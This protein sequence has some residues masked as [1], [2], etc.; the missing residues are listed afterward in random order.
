MNAPAANNQFDL[1]AYEVQPGDNLHR[2]ISR[3]YGS[4]SQNKVQSIIQQILQANDP[5]RNPNLIRPGQII[6]LSVPRQHCAA[7]KGFPHNVNL[8]DDLIHTPWFDQLNAN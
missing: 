4:M 2:I 1:V 3:Y 7:P 5:I 6:K 8:V